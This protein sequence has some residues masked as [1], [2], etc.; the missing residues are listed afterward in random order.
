[1]Q[2]H[3]LHAFRDEI[4]K[5][6]S[7][8]VELAGLGILAAPHAYNALTGKKMSHK[9]ERNAELAGLGTLASPSLAHYGSKALKFVKRA[10]IGDAMAREGIELAKKL[11]ATG[12]YKNLRG[13]ALKDYMSHM[14]LSAHPKFRQGVQVK[15]A[16]AKIAAITEGMSELEKQAFLKGLFGAAKAAPKPA[17]KPSF[18]GNAK[19]LSKVTKVRTDARGLTQGKTWDPMSQSKGR[20]RQLEFNPNA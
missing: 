1:M 15:A 17:F 12:A 16:M 13:N 19:E 14:D 3:T 9:T 11:K 6:A 5:V 8:G 2:T 20:V 18:A 10:N 4:E 7:H